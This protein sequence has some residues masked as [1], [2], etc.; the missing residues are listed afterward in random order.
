[1]WDISPSALV[2]IDLPRVLLCACEVA[3]LQ[4]FLTQTYLLRQLKPVFPVIFKETEVVSDTQVISHSP[5]PHL[6]GHTMA[7][8]ELGWSPA[9]RLVVQ[10]PDLILSWLLTWCHLTFFLLLRSGLSPPICAQAPGS[11]AGVVPRYYFWPPE[12][13]SLT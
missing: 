6:C 8:T 12:A 5:T 7:R 9:G 4:S 2:P 1:M 10:T 13:V 11:I 3:F